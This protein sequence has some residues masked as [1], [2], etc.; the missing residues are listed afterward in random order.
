MLRRRSSRFLSI[1]AAAALAMLTSAESCEEPAADP[2]ESAEPEAAAEADAAAYPPEVAEA[3][4]AEP[5]PVAEGSAEPEGSVEAA[6]VASADA[7]DGGVAAPPTDGPPASVGPISELLAARHADDLPTR[8]ALDAHP[9]AEAALVW[10]SGN[11]DALITRGRALE[12]LA[13]YP[14]DANRA[15]LLGV[16]TGSAHHKVR[17]SAV[18]GLGAWDL[19][20][21]APLRAAIEGL[22]SDASVPV[23]IAAAKALAGVAPAQPALQAIIA[24]GG[25]PPAVVTAAEASLSAD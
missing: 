7:G 3:A 22:L 23:A 20:A 24:A 19:S 13:L 12:A 10:L 14:S 17:S 15:V 16:A 2:P 5:E 1:C 9:D 4:A 25:T 8:E 21:D 6:P 18:R 11:A